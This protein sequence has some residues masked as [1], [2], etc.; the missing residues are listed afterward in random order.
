MPASDMILPPSPSAEP[1][2]EAD[3]G[4]T[5]LKFLLIPI[6]VVVG[7]AALFLMHVLGTLRRR[8]SH[9]LL[10]AVVLG[11]HT[12][13]YTLVS[14]TLGLIQEN[15]YSFLELPV[16]AVCLLMLLGGTDNLMACNLNDLDNWK[17][18]HLKHL[19]KGGLVVSIVVAYRS[20]LRQRHCLLPLV[21][22]IFVNFL[23]SYARIMSMRMA[24]KSQLL[25]K[26]LKPIADYMKHEDD[27]GQPI[28]LPDMKGYRYIVAGEDML[29]D[30]DLESIM[31]RDRKLDGVTTVEEIYGCNGPLLVSERGSRLK[32]MCLSMALSKMLNRR[33][34]GLEL[35]EAGLTKTKDFVFQ[36]LLAK[37]DK[38]NKRYERPFRVIEVELGFVYDLYYTR[39]PYLYHKGRYLALCLSLVMVFLCS[40]L[41]YELFKHRSVSSRDIIDKI[42]V[43]LTLVVMAVVTILELFQL[44]LHMASGWLKVALIRSYVTCPALHGSGSFL[45]ILM[46]LLLR[47]KAHGSWE[48]KLGQYSLLQNY[49]H[50]TSN[51]LHY[52]TL[53]LADK[54][55]MGRKSGKLVKLSTHVKQAV[56]DSLLGSNGGQLMNGVRS[57]H[58]NGVHENFSWACHGKSVTRTILVWHVATT[59]CKQKLDAASGNPPHQIT[60]VCCRRSQSSRSPN[61]NGLVPE[62]SI[63]TA[64]SS[65]A[66]DLSQ[67]CAY[68][69]AFAPDLLPDHCFDSAAV[70]DDSIKE[71]RKLHSL[72]G[73]KKT[74]ERKCEML[75][76]FIMDSGG[77]D[78]QDT[79][80]VVV[81]ARLARQLMETELRWKVLSGFWAEM[82]LYLAPCDD[83]HARD[84]LEA[85]ARGGEFI[86]HLWAL[87]THA[88]VLER[89]TAGLLAPAV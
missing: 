31:P 9:K 50:K 86:T 24:S 5:S 74:M 22:I 76:S 51:F 16:W 27:P 54:P 32:D 73:A 35:A 66:S 84:H 87:L 34:A 6:L 62:L 75:M 15:K 63:H 81:G 1:P 19:L 10:H 20:I 46:D 72:Q 55:I 58:N 36:G 56:V 48:K 13:S 61:N 40:W 52:V 2:C 78:E 45:H 59:I 88:G 7:V 68:L 11:I 43:N 71:A 17:S 4:D 37:D 18:F 89:D 85:L 3:N 57:L 29:E 79:R 77:H 65:I 12:L 28:N 23:Q 82:M 69:V 49:D 33:F 14:Y 39:Y 67:Y 80:T 64:H 70:L 38:D 8:S 83:A 26:K 25:R 53:G 44:Y 30:L 42:S 41:T 60:A 21:L 47:F